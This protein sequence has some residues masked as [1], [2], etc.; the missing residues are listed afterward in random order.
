MNIDW[1]TF[2]SALAGSAL[3]AFLASVVVHY[4]TYRT[5]CALEQHKNALAQRLSVI[6]NDMKT[7]AAMFSVW[8]QKRIDALAAIY[9]AFRAHLDFLR[10]KLY[11]P[12]QRLSLDPMWDFRNTVEKN[13]VFLNDS[14]QQDIQRFSGELLE[15]WNWAQ[16]QNR[17]GGISDTDPVQKRLD[18]EIPGYLE[19]LRR[20]IN[21]Y[22]DPQFLI[23]EPKAQQG[24]SPNGGP[25]VPL[26]NSGASEGPPSVS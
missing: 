4:L 12:D 3:P 7:K 20:V 23:P 11:L 6:E 14:L 21:S 2:W 18:Y 22:A 10:R 17:P 16:V 9:D 24:T 19:K 13:L 25:A 8:H 26:A 1:S 15:F 5:N